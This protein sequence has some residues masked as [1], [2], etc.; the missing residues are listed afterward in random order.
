MDTSA[1]EV[2][3]CHLADV[4]AG[5]G[6]EDGAMEDA[7][8]LLRES[9]T[10]EAHG[11][12]PLPTG[13]VTFLLSDIEGST[14]RWEGDEELMRAAIARHCELLGA[15]IELHGGVRPVEEGEGDSVVGAFGR[16]S[17]AVAAALDVQRAFAEESWPD[18]GVLRVR[19]ALHTGEAQLRGQGGYRGRA[20]SRGARLRAVAHGGQTVL[21]D[22]TRDLVADRLPSGA[23]LRDLGT[24]RLKDLGP[25][26]RVWQ[27]CHADI[28]VDFPPLRSLNAIIN[29]LPAQ[30]TSFV[31]RDR[32]L[33]EVG[34]AL[35][36]ARLLTLTGVGGCG[37][38]R[39]A[40][41]A[42][43]EAAE[44]FPDGV[45]WVELAPVS[46]PDLVPYVVAR[47][48]G[49][50]EEESRPVIETLAEQLAGVDAL[51]A[52][53][54]CEHLVGA[55]A[56]LVERLL[57]AA[58]ALRVVATSREALGVPG[59]V[60]WQVPSLDD[61]AATQ[62]FIERAA[63]VRPG[64]SPDADGT[65]L[66]TQICRRLDGIPLAIELAAARTRLMSPARIAAALDDRFRLLTGG[67]RTALPRQQTLETSVAWSHDLL[68]DQ[69]RAL[70]RRLA[71][72]AGGFTL[73]AAETVGAAAPLDQYAVLDVISRLVDKS[74]VHVDHDAEGRYRLLETIR[75][76]AG[77]RLVESGESDTTRDRH[78]AFFL[79]LAERA[80]PEIVRGDGADWLA[81][82]ERDHDNL[83]TA[84]E[85][86]DSTGAS[87]AF[88]RL[89]IALTLF[90]ELHSHLVAGGRWFA[91]A[92]TRDEGPSVVRA[93]ALW[94]AAHVAVYGEDLATLELRAPEALAMAEQVGDGWALG[95]ALNI[96]GL[97]QAFSEPEAARRI[98]E[99]SIELGRRTGDDWA[100][101]DGWKMLTMTWIFQDDYD[102]L[103]P[104]LVEF[105]SVSERLGSQFFIAWYHT[106][107]GWI[108]TFQGDFARARQALELALAYDAELGGG[109]TAGFATPFVGA[110]ES[111]TGAYDEALAR[112]ERFVERASASGDALGL[113]C[114]LP[115]LAQLRVGLGQPSEA[116]ALLEP[117]I[118]LSRSL[119]MA[120]YLSWDLS[121]LGRALLA[122]GDVDG[123]Q[124]ALDGAKTVAH[125][126]ANLR[127]LA[128][129]NH[130][131][132]EVAR[133]RG[134][135]IRAEDLYHES[136]SQRVERQLLPDIAES[137]E[138][139]GGV[140]CDQE[141]YR[142]ATR[143][144]GA[145]AA[146]RRSIGC[147]RW[148][149][150]VSGHEA[151][152]ARARQ[153]LGDDE[154]ESAWS[155][156]EALSIDEAVTYTCR[157]RGER[158]RP[159]AGWASLTPTELE[160][161]K[162]AAKGL[163]NPEI[164]QRLFI[165]RGTVKTHLAHVFTKLGVSTRSELAA[166]ATR[167]GL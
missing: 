151:D 97:V 85:W 50:R 140:A 74:L 35:E 166:E 23:T 131:L 61:E 37:K 116:V 32:E 108:G 68:D 98:L 34:Q 46:D 107:I 133:L 9:P 114:A 88:Q 156:G 63:Q 36:A 155:E 167:R 142:E 159:S 149:A 121:I 67:G 83:R 136:L 15:A 117:Y 65:I 73:D 134:D 81:A 17:D 59:E 161:V 28:V 47:A 126:I 103:A 84:M 100:V 79:S 54:N 138:A 163:T 51:V 2:H 125:S 57:R 58:P 29:N 24:H 14:K 66:V 21:S 38:T 77:Q 86:A 26:E 118:Q 150:D 95:R 72:F 119:G 16:P 122:T 128:M 89:T 64:F 160:V 137:L 44:R 158:K 139:L 60:T 164:G 162:L 148:P 123:A 124:G 101:V 53:D 152:V 112:L 4:L 144:V 99:R 48:F 141:S 20:V 115:F 109:A 78:L 93:R 8:D 40:L 31:G 127:L 154:F 145:A 94:G 1:D 27:L 120:W 96:N 91:R 147:A 55:C 71:V 45:R 7:V 82:L 62:L 41:H 18:G 106:T 43:A 49:L 70:L 92:L 132:G 76:Y 12:A 143:L 146:L 90:F 3:L 52:L 129:A 10:V 22:A 130:G 6:P 30:L 80:E 165:G 13:V 113:G 33:A 56:G 69:E 87:E 102:A 157:A 19:L 25:P 105:R 111:Q 135:G 5:F 104:A 75:L 39:L 11:G 153:A 110:I 42:T